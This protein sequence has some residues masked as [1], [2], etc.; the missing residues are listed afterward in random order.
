M[1]FSVEV[2]YGSVL[3]DEFEVGNL[4]YYINISDNRMYKQ[5]FRKKKGKRESDMQSFID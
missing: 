3:I 2:S 5:K 4:E 1:P